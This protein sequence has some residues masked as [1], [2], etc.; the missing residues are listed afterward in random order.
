MPT[1]TTLNLNKIVDVVVSVSPLSAPRNGFN[2]GLIIGSSTL[3][4]ATERLRF[5]SN[6]DDML[7]DGFT[8][9]EPEYL[10]AQIYFSQSPAPT[11]LWI[12]CQDLTATETMLEAVQAC[13]L[14]NSQWYPVFVCG[15]T[16]TDH[17]AIA[18]YIETATPKSTYFGT[19]SDADILTNTV[20][21]VLSTLKGLLYTRTFI[22]YSTSSPYAICGAMGYAMGQNT[23]L[24]GSAYTLKFKNEVGVAVEPL[25]ATQVLNIEDA[26]GNLYLNYGYYYNIFEQGVSSAG[27]FFDEVLNLDMLANNIQLNIMDTL[28]QNP[29]VPQTDPGVL[30]LIHACNQA[31][32]QALNIGFLAPGV[33][34]GLSILNLDTGDPLPNGYL[35]QAPAIST[36]SDA[37][38]QARKS[39]PIYIAIKEAGAIHS[40]VIGIY[41]NR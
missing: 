3:I 32:D 40:V 30:Q 34:T 36:Q 4:P 35:V 22:Q 27:R 15:A 25:T 1:P 13:R 31:C 6:T 20:G 37:D 17:E 18:A 26:N 21:N 41:V 24:A 10:A 8:A 16:K 28:Y 23:G 12:G 38:R 7:T 2:Q 19:T 5:Y 29:K 14:A 33:W 9:L 11:Q 39:P